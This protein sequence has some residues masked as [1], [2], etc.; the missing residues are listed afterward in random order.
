MSTSEPVV[1]TEPRVLTFR[2]ALNEALHEEM[3][4]D[5]RVFVIGE[6]VGRHGGVLQVTRG[7]RD[8][9]GDARVRDTPI[10]EAG[11]VGLGVGAA[12]TG[13]RAVVEVMYIDFT[14]LAIDQLVNQA[15]KARY[16]SGGKARIPLVVRTQGGAGRGNAAQHS[17]SLEAWYAHVPGLLVVMPSNPA[18]A[19]GLLKA[20]IRDDN[21]VV[22]IEHK[23]LYSTEGNVP[24][25]DWTVPL[26]EAHVKRE[27]TD[28]TVVATS[29]QVL[30]AIDAA[31]MLA[32]D[33]ISVEVV[34][35]RTVRPLD[36]DTIVASVRKTGRLVVVSEAARTG[37]LSSEIAAQV[38]DNAFWDLDA[39]IARVAGEDVPIPYSEP[40]E[41]A[42]I[43]RPETIAA[44]I[45][46]TL[47]EEP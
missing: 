35:P 22:F 23:L 24:P 6:D 17:Q 42:A 27:G 43:P 25:G 32:G 34:D 13:L 45:R 33:G 2:D 5:E 15:A 40:L 38:M 31:E 18:D 29:R 26:G 46:R 39:P 20:A 3:E 47:A 10:A 7:L 12:L 37:G 14:G 1:A 36:V 16:M 9:F 30:H 44:A 11:I 41:L 28:V 4:R 8:R 21:P 19:K